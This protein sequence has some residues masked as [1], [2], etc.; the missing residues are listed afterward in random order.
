MSFTS[1]H[2]TSLTDI[3]RSDD[4]K[5]MSADE[6]GSTP[7]VEKRSPSLP[8]TTD[9]AAVATDVTYPEGG[10]DAWLVVLG[11]WCGLTASLGIYN[12]AGVFEVV[13]S[14]VVLPEEPP[15]TLGWIFS[16]YAFVNWICGAQIGPTFDA[17]GPRALIIAGSL[18]TLIGIFSLSFCT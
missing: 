17:M 7:Y 3:T 18:C 4:G 12:T 9:S 6:K 10:R 13:I 16:I 8:T 14:K 1:R 11:A 2:S 15:A 5:E